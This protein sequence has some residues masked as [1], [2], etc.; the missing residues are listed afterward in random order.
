MIKKVGTTVISIAIC[1][2]AFADVSI[3]G[4]QNAI[5]PHS[6]NDPKGI[7]YILS[8]YVQKSGLTI[9]GGPSNINDE[10]AAK[11][12]IIGW[13]QY[14]SLTQYCQLTIRDFLTGKV[15]AHSSEWSR[16]RVGIPACIVGSVEN[17][18]NALKYSGFNEVANAENLRILIPKRPVVPLD[19]QQIKSM[20]LTSAVE[21]IWTA[22]DNRYSIGIIKDPTQK[23][24]DYIGVILQSAS[25]IWRPGEIKME[26]RET[27]N[28][29]AF[30]ANV[31]MAGK[32]RLGT[33][34]EIDNGGGTLRFDT[35]R[36][37]GT[38]DRHIW[39]K[40]YPK[41]DQIGR[42]GEGIGPTSSAAIWTGTGF[43]LSEGGLVATNYHVAGPASSLR[44]LFPKSGKEFIAKVVLKDPNNDLAILQLDAFSLAVLDQS[45][46]PY[47]FER[48]RKVSLGD[49]VFTIGFPLSDI[50]GKNAKYAN[51]TISSKSGMGDD[52]VHLQI[53]VPVQPGNS[54][55][56]LFESNGNVVGVIVS[57]V[58]DAQN[59]NY[60]IKSD[61]LINLTDMLPTVLQLGEAK[62]PPSPEQI[63]P[64]VC[65]ITAQ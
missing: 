6:D 51:G 27:A 55:S 64:F 20:R 24:G 57:R 37:D 34:I 65:L 31:Y 47:G 44:V 9:V 28:S 25:P 61:Y 18:W 52:M 33:E 2:V 16:M 12:C 11:T 15:I 63:E 49:P 58:T 30:V 36:P 23:Y 35:T 59:V 21:G 5:I 38:M 13:S 40:N 10:D 42:Q 7:Y 14:G 54:G 56:P 46:I 50:L 22:S 17:A 41:V 45:I 39:L 19:E 26:L 62:S 1:T 43:L 8:E 60:A 29:N 4:Y 32:A 3:N 48:T 53:D